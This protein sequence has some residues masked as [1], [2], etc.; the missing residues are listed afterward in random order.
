M[1]ASCFS[2]RKDQLVFLINNYDMLLSVIM[3]RTPESDECE[4]FQELLNKRTMEYVEEILSPHFGGMMTLVRDC[5]RVIETGGS[6]DRL[7]RFEQ[8]VTPLVQGFAAGWRTSVD[9]ISREVTTSFPNFKVG[10][11]V[12]QAAFTQLIQFYHRFQK[13]FTQSPFKNI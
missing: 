3:E 4:G 2:E 12:V 6:T 10:S 5:E 9:M 7:R 11:T 1:G 13:L 8:K